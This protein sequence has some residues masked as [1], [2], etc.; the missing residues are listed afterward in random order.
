MQQPPKKTETRHA[1]KKKKAEPQ[2]QVAGAFPDT[3]DSNSNGQNPSAKQ[4]RENAEAAPKARL[5][6]RAYYWV[7]WRAVNAI[8]TLAV[9]IVIAWF[10]HSQSDSTKKQW[11]ATV[12]QNEIM[13]TQIRQTYDQ[14][15]LTSLQLNETMS[16]SEQTKRSVAALE[17]QRQQ[18][19][20]SN[21]QTQQSL[22]LTRLSQG[23]LVATNAP[24]ARATNEGTVVSINL[25]NVGVFPA[26]VKGLLYKFFN[27]PYQSDV[28]KQVEDNDGWLPLAGS[29]VITNGKPT[30]IGLGTTPLKLPSGQRFSYGDKTLYVCV[31]FYYEDILG[32]VGLTCAVYYYTPT[33][34]LFITDLNYGRME[35]MR[36]PP[37]WQQR[38]QLNDEERRKLLEQHRQKINDHDSPPLRRESFRENSRSEEEFFRRT[39]S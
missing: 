6:V 29:M 15:L 24:A 10:A 9:A 22:E 21:A 14:L 37:G 36:Q 1:E 33:N 28:E 25:E 39:Q 27:A 30:T 32:N 13:K 35:L 7:N 38:Q 11:D 19:E 18:F 12:A 4:E 23:A 34:K 5:C 17:G 20:I 26:T 2:T 3:G 8:L 16:G 31:K